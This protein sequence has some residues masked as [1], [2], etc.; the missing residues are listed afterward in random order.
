P[1]DLVAGREM[2][3]ALARCGHAD[4]AAQHLE[5]VTRM[6]PGDGAAW[7][8]LGVAYMM[9]QRPADAQGALRRA[10]ATQRDAAEVHRR[11]RPG[12]VIGAQGRNDEAGLQL[13]RAI[14]LYPKDPTAWLNLGNMDRRS[15]QPDSALA[16]YRQ[17]V[18]ADSTFGMAY[19]AQAQLLVER[20][21]RDQALAVYR[22]WLR[23][24]P[25]DHLARL[26]AV[27]LLADMGRRDMATELAREGV[28]HSPRNGENHLILG[29]ALHDEGR[30]RAGLAEFELSY[31]LFRGK[32]ADRER[33]R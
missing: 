1:D 25:D 28:R 3:L 6:R 24:R 21:R 22:D 26:P 2:G 31:A 11:L 7:Y 27:G 16:D 32:P 18:A 13:R 19:Q 29:M 30:P 5:R 23:H 14:A 15:G 17:A 8:A 10:L 4:V 12:T 20:G 9:S 33:V